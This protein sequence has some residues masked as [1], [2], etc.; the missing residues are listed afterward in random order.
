MDL[1]VCVAALQRVAQAPQVLHSKPVKVFTRWAHR[2]PKG[3]A[4]HRIEH[5]IKLLG[6]SDSA[7][8]REGGDNTGHA[9]RV[10]VVAFAHDNG[11]DTL[12]SSE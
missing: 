12:A 5:P 10:C 9:V 1:A 8:K 4:Y 2:N 11:A 7:F 3:L 6:F